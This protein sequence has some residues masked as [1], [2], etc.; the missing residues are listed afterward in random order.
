MKCALIS[1]ESM[2][3]VKAETG[4]P[5]EIYTATMLCE[6]EPTDGLV[7]RK[8]DSTGELKWT[9]THDGLKIVEFPLES[10]Q[11]KSCL[12]QAKE[13]GYPV[14]VEI[15]LTQSVNYKNQM[16]TKMTGIK[17]PSAKLKTAG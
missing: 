4:S 12:S 5:Y 14:D 11:F 9:R 8:D 1:L 6:A 2:K 17:F 7:I 3:G 16:V 15:T 13:T 10:D